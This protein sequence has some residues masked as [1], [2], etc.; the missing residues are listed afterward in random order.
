LLL[1]QSFFLLFLLA[2]YIFGS[3]SW[4]MPVSKWSQKDADQV[5]N[6]SPWAIRTD[7]TM[8]DP[9][10][11]EEQ[12]LPTPPAGEGQPGARTTSGPDNTRWD[13]AITKNRMGHL[14]TIPVMVRWDSASVVRQALSFKHAADAPEVAAA[15]SG[16][17]II[18]VDGLLP[19]SQLRDAPTLQAK[20]SSADEDGTRTR[21][22]EELLEWFMT[23]SRLLVK[24]EKPM[25]PQNVRVDPGSG[26][27]LVFFK[28]NQEL[29]DH[30]KDVL[31]STRFGSMS[32]ET[33]FRTK[34]MFV[35]GH[36]DL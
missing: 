18:E 4:K 14:A 24:G 8:D 21:T 25:V 28:R 15:A 30:K 5:L 16:N 19:S 27:V 12:P 9:K 29:L 36:A 17:F 3:D 7:A 34:D 20:S 32:V 6:A 26:T 13:G 10:D 11:Q 1:K 33:R 2:P 31:F 23:N 22:A 35:D